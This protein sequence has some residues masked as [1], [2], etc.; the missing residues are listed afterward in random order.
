MVGE[1]LH[2]IRGEGNLI[3]DDHVMSWT[4][5]SLKT[6]VSLKV[7]LAQYLAGD[8]TVDDG[9]GERV[10]RALASLRIEIRVFLLGGI[11]PRVVTLADDDD[12]DLGVFCLRTVELV[13]SL[14]EA[15]KLVA[16]DKLILT[17][18]NSITVDHN[19][20]RK[21]VLVLLLPQPETLKHHLLQGINH[22][23]LALLSPNTARPLVHG[24]IDR[25]HET[26][27]AGSTLAASGRRVCHV[28]ADD[29]GVVVNRSHNSVGY[30]VRDATTLQVE[31][32]AEVAEVHALSLFVQDLG[33]NRANCSN[34]VGHISVGI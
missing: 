3:F 33:S 11:E 16:Q 30:A 1:L 32:E 22:F 26:S 18:R 8:A 9:A 19:L 27:D 31:L 20:H 28:N 12:G 25:G 17:F 10:P 4:C 7:E 2:L 15:R 21:T 29:H 13:E 5:R 6:L 24:R 34:A 23:L 14:L